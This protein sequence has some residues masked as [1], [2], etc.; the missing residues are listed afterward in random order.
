ML[1]DAKLAREDRVEVGGER[2]V[3]D[4]IDGEHG[5]DG[6]ELG[7]ERRER[8]RPD[9]EEVHAA[10]VG[11]RREEEEPRWEG[12]AGAGEHDLIERVREEDEHDNEEVRRDRRDEEAR[13]QR[14][15]EHAARDGAE[16]PEEEEE[17]EDTRRAA[18]KGEVGDDARDEDR[19]VDEHDEDARP[20][21]LAA[22]VPL[23]AQP[24]MTISARSRC[25]F[26]RTPCS[27][28]VAARRSS[29]ADRDVDEQQHV[30]ARPLRLALV[31]Q[32][33]SR[34]ALVRAFDP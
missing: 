5:E 9:G 3:E 13:V 32:Q 7:G 15:D 28:R 14:R 10:I 12:V 30:V 24:I 20:E 16:R 21:P 18:D 2:G 34:G 25:S 26:S 31:A 4:A 33:L 1:R 27:R 29:R 11:E 23:H 8:V 19:H 22:P 17:R 6:A